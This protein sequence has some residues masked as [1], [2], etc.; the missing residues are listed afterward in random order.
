MGPKSRFSMRVRAA[1]VNPK[2][3]WIAIKRR[4]YVRLY[5]LIRRHP[6]LV[7][8]RRWDNLIVLDACRF[9]AFAQLN[10]IPGKLS[11]MISPGSKTEE[12]MIA[13]FSNKRMKDV[14]YVSANPYVS[15]FN[16]RQ[17]FGTNPF[18]RVVEVWKY[19][20]SEELETVHPFAVNEATLINLKKHSEK[21]FIIHY[22]QPHFPFIG[23]YRIWN[24]GWGHIRKA[25]L[26][27]S[28]DRLEPEGYDVWQAF[29]NGVLDE[30]S[31][32][33]AYLS[34]LELVLAYVEKLLPRLGGVT[35]IT[36]DHGSAFGKFGVFYKHPGKTPL[37][38]LIEVP[39]L[40]VEK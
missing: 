38:E 27:H 6:D 9:D 37:P 39:W 13:N 4:S 24:K 35:C 20:W 23:K 32:W 17:M 40:E 34:N 5:G 29:E 1:L 12:W 28:W 10:K 3:L 30:L 36:S 25:V 8:E 22:I 31:V 14:I 2:K 26:R 33:K 7:T 19:G 18:Y 21:R 15:H 16:L 11:K